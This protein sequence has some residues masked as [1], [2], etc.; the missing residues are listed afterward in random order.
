MPLE[1]TKKIFK[2]KNSR[3]LAAIIFCFVLSACG[4]SAM[5]NEL[6]KKRELALP[7][8]IGRVVY[9]DV[10]DEVRTVGNIQSEKRVELA[11]EITGQILDVPIEEGRRVRAG[12]TLVVIDPREYELELERLESER[13]AAEK[14]YE[15]ALQGLRPEEQER[16]E[17]QV[18]A[19]ESGWNLTIKEQRRIEKLVAEEV[20]A[21]SVLDEAVD[22]TQR[23]EE[24]VRASRAALEAGKKSRGEDIAQK[25]SDL[26]GAIKKRAMAELELSKTFVLAPFDGVIVS[27]KIEKGALAQPGTPLMEMIS[28]SRLKAVIELPQ[29]YRGKL[30]ELTKVQF[31]IPELNLKFEQNKDLK[32]YVRVIPDANIFSGNIQVQIN[33]VKPDPKIFPGLTLE[34]L[35]QFQTR[36]RALHVPSVSL[37]ISEQGSAVYIVKDERAQL[38]PVKAFKEKDGFVEV[39]DFTHQLKGGEDLVLRGSGAV[40]PGV[41]VFITNPEFK[42]KNSPSA[43][44]P[45]PAVKNSPPKKQKSG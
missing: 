35:M 26:D 28:S 11:S 5:N 2:W 25:K 24:T 3:P 41:K 16:L 38:V 8:Q 15:K 7:V 21:V 27:K 31:F 39:D 10:V 9:K 40:F 4:D 20:L 22:K 12:Q 36:K 45:Q 44:S 13:T 6:P 37:A 18:R 1:Y 23:A 32:K 17:A 33:L 19:D 14:E 30:P 34:C 43:A 42:K 29:S